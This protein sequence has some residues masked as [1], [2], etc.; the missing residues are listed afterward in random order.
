MPH[1]SSLAS[2]EIGHLHLHLE[3]EQSTPAVSLT[4]EEISPG[5]SLVHLEIRAEETWS[6]TPLKL[7]W[8]RP[9][10][11]TI[12]VWCSASDMKRGLTLPWEITVKSKATSQA[13]VICLYG[14]DGG[15]RMTIACSEV[16]EHIESTASVHEATGTFACHVL[17]F[18][19]PTAPL[20]HYRAT[21]RIDLRPEPFH[22][23]LREVQ[24]WW[25]GMPGIAPSPVPDAARW[26]MYSTWYSFHQEM[27]DAAVEEQCRLSRELGCEAVIIDDGWQTAD[28]AGGYAYCGEWEVYRGKFPDMAAHVERIHALGMKCLL[29]YSV[30]FIGFKSPAYQRFQ[31]KFLVEQDY[32]QAAVLDPRFPE[33]REFLI[34]LYENAIREWDL[35]G[36]KLDFVDSFAP[37]ATSYT[38]GMEGRDIV[39]VP[40]AVDRLMRDVNIRLRRLK[41]DIMIEFRQSYVGPLMRNYGN[42]FRAHDCPNDALT[43]RV[44][45]VDVR[46]LAG[47]TAVHSD[48]LMWSNH[49]PVASAA[50]QLLNI[51]FSVPQVSVRIDEIP[52]DHRQML[53]FW[54]GFWREHREVLLDGDFQPFHPEQFYPFVLARGASSWIGAIYANI[55]APLGNRLPGE[56]WL[57]NATPWSR[58]LVELD[59]DSGRYAVEEYDVLGR[60]VE[61]RNITLTP[62]LHA[63]KV[64]PS[65]LLHLR[66]S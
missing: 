49:E 21:I 11:D 50:L 19:Q 12:G 34:G 27:T 8:R 13:P 10:I 66:Q 44:R 6:P 33:V 15:N 42:M 65:G 62:G 47:N 63:L 35:D 3:G 53:A 38:D 25:A 46:L 32:F 28:N 40:D 59:T 14:A 55:A 39:S 56:L 18:S 45:I 2:V 22:R 17:F 31:G 4:A 26:P 5:L 54:L 7:S 1:P 9:I 57:V 51:L 41:P 20:R 61:S 29:W 30:P 37:S 43:N 64:G 24:E 36:L 48:M 58:V 16:L 60:P 23:S 52:E